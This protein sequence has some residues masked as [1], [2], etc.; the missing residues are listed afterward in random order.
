M[1]K[2]LAK[3]I[4]CRNYAEELRIIAADKLD[5]HNSSLLLR[6]ADSYDKMA[7]SLE[8]LEQLRRE[9]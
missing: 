8:V 1:G 2:D 3:A 5:L 7:E 4:R 9:E 6:V